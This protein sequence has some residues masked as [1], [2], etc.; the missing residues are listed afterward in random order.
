MELR[1]VTGDDLT[2]LARLFDAS[3]TLTGCWCMFFLLSGKEFEQGW[4]GANRARFAAL[5]AATPQPMGLLAYRDGEPVGWCATGPRSRYGRIL[6]SPLMKGRDASEDESVWL[7]PCFFV[8]RDARRTGVTRTLLH[9]AVDL[10]A[11]HGAAAVEGVPLA[12]SGRHP[13]AEAYV[14]TEPVFTA[15]GFEPTSRP[16]PK[17]LVMRHT[18]GRTR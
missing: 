1:P 8:R 9:A 7:V 16:S 15:C 2:D 13:T 12:G 6:R 3:G 10:A 11:E 17:R 5:A 14:G 4:G 18:F